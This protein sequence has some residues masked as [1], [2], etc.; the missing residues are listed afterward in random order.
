MAKNEWREEYNEILAQ[1]AVA[2]IAHQ[3]THVTHP[4]SANWVPN[5]VQ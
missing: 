2:T 5:I 1:R 4:I 3:S